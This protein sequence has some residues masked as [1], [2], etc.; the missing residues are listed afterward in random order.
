MLRVYISDNENGM[1]KIDGVDHLE[2]ILNT[3]EVYIW[4]TFKKEFTVKVFPI[5]QLLT[6][7]PM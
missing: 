3:F 6:V 7:F 1:I 4:D 5:S 2:F